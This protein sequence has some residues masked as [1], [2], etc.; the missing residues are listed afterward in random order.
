MQIQN[1]YLLDLPQLPTM[2][3]SVRT[4]P[5]HLA[6]RLEFLLAHALW[7]DELKEFG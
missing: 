6:M 3:Q 4:T 2:K 1:Q 7:L 5:M